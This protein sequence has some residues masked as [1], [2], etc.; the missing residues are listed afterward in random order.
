M[1]T[2]IYTKTARKGVI[3][4]ADLFDVD[5]TPVL[6]KEVNR[7]RHYMNRVKGY[8]MQEDMYLGYIK[9]KRAWVVIHE[10]DTG[11]ILLSDAL[12][13][14]KKGRTMSFTFEDGSQRFLGERYMEKLSDMQTAKEWIVGHPLPEVA[15]QEPLLRF[16]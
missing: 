15:V 1:S 8:G 6:F 2:P 11:A 10:K 14:D 16:P 13:W 5:D 4:A 3:H 12:T 7:R 9:E